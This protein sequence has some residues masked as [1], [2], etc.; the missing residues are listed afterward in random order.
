LEPEYAVDALTVDLEVE[1]KK[2]FG[3]AVFD[4][5]SSVEHL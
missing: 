3:Q 1:A 4:L 5:V 2:T